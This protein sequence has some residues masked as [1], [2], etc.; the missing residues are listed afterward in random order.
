MMMRRAIPAMVTLAA[1]VVMAGCS[2]AAPPAPA[3]APATGADL[4]GQTLEVA[5]VW[6]DEEQA[7]FEKVLAGFEKATGAKVTYTSA[8]DELPT[9]LQTRIAGGSPPDVA[10][11]PQPGLVASLSKGGALKP[12][13]DATATVV[14][15]QFAPVWKQLGTADGKLYGVVFK[16]AN[17]STVWYDADTLGAGWKAPGTFAE[18]V[19]VLRSQSDTG[20]TPLSVGGADG[21]TLTDWFENVYLQTAGPENYDKLAKHEIPWTDPTVKA[22]LAELEKAFQPQFIPGGQSSALQTEFS[23]SV[24]NVFSDAP[25]ASIVYEGDFVAGVIKEN[26]KATVGKDANFFP[27][28]TVASTPAVVS[29]GD[30]VVA[31]S[32][33]P[34]TQALVTYLAGS[35]AA[36]IWAAEGGFISPN[37]KVDLG[38]YPDDVTR[39]IAEGLSTATT[40]R[41]DMSDLMPSALGGTKGAGFWKAMQDFLAEPASVDTILADLEAQAVTAYK[42]S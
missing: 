39:K 11:L 12:L 40:V 13:G 27:F 9:V 24:V 19:D 18:F 2:A 31:L 41:F 20:K 21:W 5:A 42:G 22:A 17:K 23:D 10:V 38:T 16:A 30:T 1:A 29:G 6:A 15:E 36:S 3:A 7:A 35:D 37:K 4:A 8:G 32:D 14:D 33:K 28:P 26:T 25:S 34:A